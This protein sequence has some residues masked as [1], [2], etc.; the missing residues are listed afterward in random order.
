[1]IDAGVT[2]SFSG[3]HNGQSNDGIAHIANNSGTDVTLDLSSTWVHSGH[4][5]DVT[6]EVHGVTLRAGEQRDVRIDRPIER[7]TGQGGG[8]YHLGDVALAHVVA[9]PTLIPD[10]PN[11][12][13][14]KPDRPTPQ[15]SPTAIPTP[16]Q[17][18]PLLVP[19]ATQTR[20]ADPGEDSASEADG[21]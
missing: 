19:T 13:Q 15:K 11:P 3:G 6:V 18:V 9:D 1:M 12:D 21:D 10:Q 2:V 8:G 4:Q 16:T 20:P 17:E 14:P 7:R 5:P